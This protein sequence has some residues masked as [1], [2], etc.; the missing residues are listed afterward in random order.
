MTSG[1]G[2]FARSPYYVLDEPGSMFSTSLYALGQVGYTR[3]QYE[4]NVTPLPYI[5]YIY[6]YNII[7]CILFP[8]AYRWGI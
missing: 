1:T 6:T 2:Y 5:L 7:M 4:P 8:L 3:E